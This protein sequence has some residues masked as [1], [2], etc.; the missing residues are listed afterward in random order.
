MLQ[1]S[2]ALETGDSAIDREHREIFS[3]LNDIGAAIDR[4]A[5]PEAL[6]HLIHVLLDYAHRHFR[7]E[8]H[9]MACRRCPLH[10]ANCTAHGSFTARM[11]HWLAIMNCGV[12][13]TSLI[14][15][16]HRELCEWIQQHIAKI[17]TGLRSSLAAV[18]P[19]APA[20]P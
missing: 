2:E 5:D 15:D 8:E 16:I 4:G 20:M 10:E 6:Q 17:D 3:R 18:P 13:P 14:A 1:W 11:V 7:H 9:V 19:V 12:V